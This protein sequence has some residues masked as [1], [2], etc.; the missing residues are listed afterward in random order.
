LFAF[1][2][3]LPHALLLLSL[4]KIWWDDY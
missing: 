2:L 1:L 4:A 3:R